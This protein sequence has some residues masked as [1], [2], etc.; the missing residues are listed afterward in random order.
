MQP[1]ECRGRSLSAGWQVGVWK[2]RIRTCVTGIALCCGIPML[3]LGTTTQRWI[4]LVAIYL[5]YKGT[6]LLLWRRW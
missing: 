2:D 5:V 4:T 6:G 3:L 1:W